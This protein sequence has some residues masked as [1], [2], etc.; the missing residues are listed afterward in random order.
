MRY[1]ILLFLLIELS[2]SR[3]LLAQGVQFQ[4]LRYDGVGTYFTVTKDDHPSKLVLYALHR[5]E[6]T[7]AFYLK[8]SG[9]PGIKVHAK[10]L[11]YTGEPLNA[12]HRLKS[13]T[14]VLL[15]DEEKQKQFHQECLPLSIEEEDPIEAI[16]IGNFPPTWNEYCEQ[17]GREVLD[18]IAADFS[19]LYGGAWSAENVCS[20]LMSEVPWDEVN[21]ST[22]DD[23]FEE[24]RSTLS[25]TFH[26]LLSANSCRKR[27]GDYLL[28]F[29]LDFSKVDWEGVSGEATLSAR[30][31][32]ILHSGPEEASIKPESEG[33]YAPKPLILMRGL[34][35]FCGHVI[36]VVRWGRKKPKKRTT[37]RPYS[38]L[39]WGGMTLAVAVADKVVPGAGKAT[40]E[41]YDERESYGVCFSLAR[42]RQKANG[43]P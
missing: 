21:E 23:L 4:E 13:G 24:A 35:G 2:L 42:K 43:Y 40:F 1:P 19:L 26:G 27:P 25:T 9:V 39:S 34:G 32:F 6:E 38:M 10:E 31:K 36:D 18:A 12:I 3:M 11:R 30:F 17:S 8:L 16:D 14:K 28:R 41:L 15:R 5:T 33:R 22:E 20:Y 37:L 7:R 29:V